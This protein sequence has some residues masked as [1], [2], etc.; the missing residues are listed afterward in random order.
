MATDVPARVAPLQG[1]TS[2]RARRQGGSAGCVTPCA[3]GLTA[4]L[5]R[6][7][8]LWYR[9]EIEENRRQGRGDK[10]VTVAHRASEGPFLLDDGRG[11]CLVEPARAR[12]EPR[13]QEVWHGP[14]RNPGDRRRGGG[15]RWGPR[16]PHPDRAS[17]R[18]IDTG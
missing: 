10:W 15:M 12:V 4:P 9:Y 2:P 13:G 16:P 5:T 1:E 8:F 3:N 7:P 17:G 18:L 14:W 6:V 11:Q